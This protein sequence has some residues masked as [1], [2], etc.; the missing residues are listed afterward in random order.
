LGSEY[1]AVIKKAFDDRWLDVYPTTGKRSGAYSNGSIYDVH[2]Y[3]LLN[4]NGKYDDVSTLAHE[5]GHTMQSYLSNKAQPYPIADYPIFTAE[6]ASTFN[7]AL[8]NDD[9]QIRMNS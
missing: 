8:L 4:F 5:L 1:Q 9:H 3:M 2:P 7:E 6:V